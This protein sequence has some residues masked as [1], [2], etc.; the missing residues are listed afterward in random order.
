MVRLRRLCVRAC[1][2]QGAVLHVLSEQA[3]VVEGVLGFPRHCVNRTLVH[4]VLDG[5]EQ[6]IQ[7]LPCRVL[8]EETEKQR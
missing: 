1:P 4:L 2:H 5:P 3:V 7:R 6:H 8:G